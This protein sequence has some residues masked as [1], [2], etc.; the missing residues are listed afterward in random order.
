MTIPRLL[1]FQRLLAYWGQQANQWLENAR[2]AAQ[3]F[4]KKQQLN[5]FSLRG[6]EADLRALS[7]KVKRRIDLRRNQKEVRRRL[8]VKEFYGSKERV[9]VQ[10]NCLQYYR[11]NSRNEGTRH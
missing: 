10:N 3:I 6:Q 1:A 9:V 4:Q 8:K 11:R 2:I 7:S 5:K